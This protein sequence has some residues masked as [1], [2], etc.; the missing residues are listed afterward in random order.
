MSQR[1]FLPLDEDSLDSELE[2]NLSTMSAM[3]Y[4]KQVRFERK[5]IP[6][7][8]TVHP[9]RVLEASTSE[10]SMELIR[11]LHQLTIDIILEL[12]PRKARE[13]FPSQ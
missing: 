5:N 12:K 6:Q 11:K 1:Q 2:Y 7:V 8:V 4:L 13:S 9:L 10:V 3:D